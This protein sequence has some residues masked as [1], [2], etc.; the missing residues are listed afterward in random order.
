[1]LD[2]ENQNTN[3][4]EGKENTNIASIDVDSVYK[5]KFKKPYTFEGQTYEGIDLSDI[6]NI[7]TKDLVETDKLFYATGNIAPS[8]EMSMAYALIVASK[9][10]KK[11]LEFFTNLPGREGVKVKTAVVNFL[12]N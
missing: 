2:Q 6:E 3:L 11:P 1:M 10:A 8:T 4:E 9:A 12:Y 7:S 5:I